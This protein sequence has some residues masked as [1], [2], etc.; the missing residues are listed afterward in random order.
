[1]RGQLNQPHPDPP[2]GEGDKT[3]ILLGLLPPLGEGRGGVDLI[4]SYY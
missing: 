4:N 2:Q 3:M 1:M